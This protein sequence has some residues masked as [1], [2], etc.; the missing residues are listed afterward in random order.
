[1]ISKTRMLSLVRGCRWREVRAALAE[2]SGLVGFR[3]KKGRNWLHLCCGVNIRKRRVKA[4]D[5]I[6]TVEILLK[7]GL[8]IDH[9]AFR[10]GKWKAT[11]LWYSIAFGR[12]R[13]LSEY[14]LERGSNPNHCLWAAAYNN[15]AGAIRLLI[16]YGAEDPSTAEASPFLAAIQ[17]NRF[18]AAIELLKLGADINFQDS[19]KQMTALHY[20]LQKGSDKKYVRMLIRYGARGDLKN[21]SGVTAAEIM[22]RKRDPDFRDMAARLLAAS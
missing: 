7:A 17:W 11:P 2:N 19:K 20:V 21:G 5:S 4:A 15:D 22:M 12:N 1:M 13:A 3:D 8:D 16:H 18:A 9:A 6:R 10:E 14:L